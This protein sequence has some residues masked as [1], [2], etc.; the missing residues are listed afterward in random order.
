M[1]KKYF[2]VSNK[3]ETCYSNCNQCISGLCNK[4]IAHA[5]LMNVIVAYELNAAKA[6]FYL[7]GALKIVLTN[8]RFL[9]IP[10]LSMIILVD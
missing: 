3:S 1:H 6:T 9:V 5:V 10:I 7:M 4:W 8:V 2:F